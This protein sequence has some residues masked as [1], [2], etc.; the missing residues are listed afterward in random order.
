MTVDVKE[1]EAESCRATPIV[2][3]DI[4]TA[5]LIPELEDPK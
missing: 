5:I 3:F 1:G 4:C 2:S